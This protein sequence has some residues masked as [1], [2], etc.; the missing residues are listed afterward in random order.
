MQQL[1]DEFASH[2]QLKN[3][4]NLPTLLFFMHNADATATL[5]VREHLAELHSLGYKQ[6][7]TTFNEKEGGLNATY[8]EKLQQ[9]LRYTKSAMSQQVDNQLK[10]KL[11]QSLVILDEEIKLADACDKLGMNIDGG[12]PGQ[13]STLGYYLAC[14]FDPQSASYRALKTKYSGMEQLL[15]QAIHQEL[16]ATTRLPQLL[17]EHLHKKIAEAERLQPGGV[18]AMLGY[19]CYTVQRQLK[20]L[21]SSTSLLAGI[22]GVKASPMHYLSYFLYG[23]K[24]V[25]SDLHYA[26]LTGDD[27]DFSIL[28]SE[29]FCLGLSREK[30]T[31]KNSDNFFKTMQEAIKSHT[32]LTP[33][34]DDRI[35]PKK[36]LASAQKIYTSAKDSTEAKNKYKMAFVFA[37]STANECQHLGGHYRFLRSQA[38]ILAAQSAD[39]L[40]DSKFAFELYQQA[41]NLRRDLYGTKHASID[42]VDA[43]IK[44]CLAKI[45]ASKNATEDT[46]TLGNRL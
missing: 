21:Q 25:D 42:E 13:K 38:L 43:L 23:E 45:V 10:D 8:I 5:F 7:I 32:L 26:A 12:A 28:S 15:P 16:M 1:P 41:R 22:H 14:G 36:L 30:L 39:E 19:D 35:E 6:V 4:T 37:S 9:R 3:K 11:N 18:I 46:E 40:G 27:E 2:P 20:S 17:D 34:L 33:Y 29:L 31:T 24:P 44:C